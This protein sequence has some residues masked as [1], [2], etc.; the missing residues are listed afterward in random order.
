MK[1]LRTRP[2]QGWSFDY[3]IGYGS[4]QLD[5]IKTIQSSMQGKFGLEIT[6]RFPSHITHS[7]AVGYNIGRHS[8]GSN[9]SYLT[10]GGRL[11]RADY[12]GSYTVDMIMNGYRVGAFYRH[13][14]KTGFSPVSIYL[15]ISPGV[16][17]SSLEI[18]EQVTVYTESDQE[19]TKLKGHG[20]YTEPTIGVKYNLSN[21][22]Q[23]SLGGG[24]E[25]DFLSK[26]KYSGQETNVEALWTGFRF[27]GG[28]I[29][30]LPTTK[31][32]TQ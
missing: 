26:M 31:K 25:I 12:S 17:F 2:S 13:S 5:G 15:Q 21:Y 3:S 24:Y 4:Y 14:I 29:F 1:T 7:A 16:L 20:F 19:N 32:I 6:D 30:V 27:Y 9:F 18:N 23:F 28:L 10:T 8:F 22:L 11:H